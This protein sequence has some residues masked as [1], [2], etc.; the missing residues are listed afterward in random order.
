MNALRS[1]EVL[2]FAG[3]AETNGAFKIFS[4]A[5]ND[6]VTGGAGNDQIYG[7]AGADTLAGGLGNDT[8]AYISAAHSTAAGQDH[9]LDFGTGT[10]L[11]DLSVIDANANTPGTNDAFAFI[12]ASAF[13][14]AA[15]Q[16]RAAPA[17][18]ANYV[19]EGDTNGDGVADLS[20]LVTSSHALGTGDFVL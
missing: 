19:V 14:G 6:T 2:T 9:I 10:D 7:G 3:A 12:G 11:I 17:G 16:L 13:T 4:G 1:N 15:G 5:G 20:I 18:G 8:F